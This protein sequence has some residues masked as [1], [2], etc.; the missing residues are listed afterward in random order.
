M[1]HAPRFLL[2]FLCCT[3]AALPL[4][5]QDPH[6]VCATT[7]DLAALCRAIGGDRVDVTCFT[8]GPEDPHFV[9]A[10]PSMVRAISRAEVLVEIGRELEIGWLPLLVDNGRNGKVLAGQGS[11]IVAGDVVRRLGVPQGSVDRSQGDVHAAGN[12]HFLGDPLCGLQ[13]AQLLCDRFGGL[14]P[15]ERDRFAQNLT[16]FRKRLATAMVGEKVAL[17]YGHDAEKLASLFPSGKLEELLRTQGDLADLGG[18]FGALLPLRGSTVVADHDLW[19]YFAE[20]FG[21]EVVGFFEPKPG[22]APTTAHLQGLVQAMKQK[23]VRA[24][25]SSPYFAPQHAELVA[26]NTGA[27][28]A[29]MAHQVGARPGTDDYVAF[30][31]Y[32]VRCLC[33]ALQPEGVR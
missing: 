26:R 13:V 32:N 27:S 33:K 3:G 15:A 20:R 1:S 6:V 19:P 14:W 4:P 17:L 22:V 10:R 16:D 2:S 18:W 12:P 21:F 29:A 9:E 24:I 31:D 7:P 23:H 30:V 25:L 28:I 5:G 8:R 11:R